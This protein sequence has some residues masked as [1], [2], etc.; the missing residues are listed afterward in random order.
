[1]HFEPDTGLKKILFAHLMFK[2]GIITRR[3]CI[4]GNN[5]WF[6]A[7]N[8]GESKTQNTDN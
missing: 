8:M 3:D 2:Y 1:M 6:G 5:I 4:A 7:A